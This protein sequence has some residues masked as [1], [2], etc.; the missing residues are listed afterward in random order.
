MQSCI[1][2]SKLFKTE[3]NSVRESVALARGRCQDTTHGRYNVRKVRLSATF[4]LIEAL[5]CFFQ[6]AVQAVTSEHVQ[7][8]AQKLAA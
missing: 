6:T 3:K 5:A 4:T 8:S 2:I 1:F 7:I